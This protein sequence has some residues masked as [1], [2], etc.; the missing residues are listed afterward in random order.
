MGG[1]KGTG[2]CIGKTC[3]CSKF[4]SSLQYIVCRFVNLF[5]CKFSIIFVFNDSF[6]HFTALARILPLLGFHFFS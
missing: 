1:K 3:A 4:S 6:V 2:W 5:E